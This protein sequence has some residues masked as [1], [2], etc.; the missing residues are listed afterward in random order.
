[1]KVL[2][3][4]TKKEIRIIILGII[5]C[6]CLIIITL[7]QSKKE[8]EISS[9]Q[10]NAVLYMKEMISLVSDYCNK[11]GIIIDSL[12]DPG[13]TGLIG[14]EMTGIVTTLGDPEAKRTSI[15]PEMAELI[16]KLL[17]ESGVK[18]KDT[19]SLGCSGSFPG[20]LLASLSAANAMNLTCKSIISVGASSYGATRPEFTILDIYMLLLENDLTDAK[21]V[22]V[23]LGGEDDNASD[24]D[25][26]VKKQITDKIL[27]SGFFLIECLHFKDCVDLRDSLCGFSSSGG[28]KVFINAG[29][30]MANIGTSSTILGMKPGIVRNFGIPP[31]NQQGAIHRAL[32]AGIPVIH[33]L[34]LK[35]LAREYGL[36]WDPV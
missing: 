4:I 27:D 11:T 5:S 16:V 35:G 8:T 18:S 3:N 36:K 1:M 9:D 20:L 12:A 28:V 26:S 7:N 15:Q 29:G 10:A 33:L 21:P 17:K 6:I 25:P 22:G 2:I 30:A 34:N 23:S 24:W 19:I 31:Q 14:P 32:L 13:K